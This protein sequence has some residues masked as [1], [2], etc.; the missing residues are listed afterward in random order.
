MASIEIGPSIKDIKILKNDYPI[1]NVSNLD[2]KSF[3]IY[4]LH[5]YFILFL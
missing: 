3:Y 2:E 4:L 1:F 5:F